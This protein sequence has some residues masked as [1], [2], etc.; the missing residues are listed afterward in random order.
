MGEMEHIKMA[1]MSRRNISY[2][3]DR[4]AGNQGSRPPVGCQAGVEKYVTGS[5]NVSIPSKDQERHNKS[6][7]HKK[8]E[9]QIGTKFR[10]GTINV[11]TARE[12]IKL[13]E[14][15]THAKNIKQDVCCF[16]ETRRTGNGEIEYDDEI[17]KGWKV[18]YSGFKQRSQGGVDADREDPSH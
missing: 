16:Q 2:R 7:N 9:K 1:Q 4:H 14:Y 10:I 15:V 17:L 18:F 3:I 11:R 13:T 8:K 12:E 6:I 5:G